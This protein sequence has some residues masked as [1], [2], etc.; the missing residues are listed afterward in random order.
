[1][2]LAVGGGCDRRRPG[3]AI[4]ASTPERAASAPGSA[5][6]QPAAGSA[7]ASQRPA[8]KASDDAVAPQSDAASEAA[9]PGSGADAADDGQG[10]GTCPDAMLEVR[11]GITWMGTD[12]DMDEAPRHQVAVRSFCLDRTEV[13]VDRYQSCVEAGRCTP[14]HPDSIGCTA[15]A[16][17]KKHDHPINC[18]DWNQARA[19]CAAWGN[20]LPAEREWEFAACGGPERRIYSWGNELPDGRSCYNQRSTCA[21]GS[22]SPGAFGLHDMTGNV[23]EWTASWFGPYPWEHE[24]GAQRVYRGGSYSRRF[25]RW[26]R[27]G[28]RNRFRP[29]EWGAHLGFRCAADLPDAACPQGSHAGD[30]PGSC[31]VDGAPKPA[32]RDWHAPAPAPSGSPPDAGLPPVAVVRDPTYDEDC[33]KYKP[34]RP[35][36]F[37]VTGGGFGDRETE[38]ATRG[39]VNRDVGVGF[40]S[41]CCPP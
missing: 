5:P 21:V 34:G 28:L 39:C 41:I 15:G 19:A 13:T 24:S 36:C 7:V 26:M 17:D 38:R 18:V 37:K 16:R 23:W 29:S 10:A 32:R 8:A 40:S 14:A 33:V 9:G 1:V 31:D 4:S 12:Y 3:G 25:P 30:S 2:A 35:V 20:R 22:Y 11:G 6:L 27:T